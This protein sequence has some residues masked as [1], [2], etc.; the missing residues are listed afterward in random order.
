MGYGRKGRKPSEIPKKELAEIRRKER[1]ARRRNKEIKDPKKASTI[2]KEKLV[3]DLGKPLTSQ[4][5]M[6][7][8][9]EER[10]KAF[11][12]FFY[13]YNGN[14]SAACMAVGITRATYNRWLRKYPDVST[15]IEEVNEALLDLAEQQLLKNI[16]AGKENS[17]FFFLCNKGKHRGWADIRKL[18]G[19]KIA[20]MNI[21]INYPDQKK[22]L[23][24]VDVQEVEVKVIDAKVTDK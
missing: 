10:R 18:S 2:V 20:A 8:D 9:S 7:V 14:I 11:I 23:P 3:E 4:Q 12:Q 16:E 19:P 15:H 6:M 21:N 13:R 24:H 1:A 5:I 17:L 22:Q